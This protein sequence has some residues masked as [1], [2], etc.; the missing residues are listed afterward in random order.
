MQSGT[1]RRIAPYRPTKLRDILQVKEKE[2][3]LDRGVLSFKQIDTILQIILQ[4]RGLWRF[5]HVWIPTTST[6]FMA[7]NK[8]PLNWWRFETVAPGI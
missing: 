3:P 8:L 7:R 1:L 4:Q 6:H 2:H 5:H